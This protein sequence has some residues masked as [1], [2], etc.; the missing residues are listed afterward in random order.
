MNHLA[1]PH[2]IFSA[3]EAELAAAIACGPP[4]VEFDSMRRSGS[5]AVV[6]YR[7]ILVFAGTGSG[8]EAEE[9]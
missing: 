7:L 5:R 9:P 2:G 8:F 6:N 1:T 3:A 4:A